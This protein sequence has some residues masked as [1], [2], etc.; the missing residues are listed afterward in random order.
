M[1]IYDFWKAVL[2]QNEIE[3]RKYF[4]NDAYINWHCTNEQFDVD[5]FIIANCEYPGDWE[6]NVER[7]ETLNDLIVTVV[8]VYPKG[9]NASF[10][11]TSFIKTKE[12]KIVSM[13][14]YW[15]DDGNAP[16][17][18]LDKHI[19]KTKKNNS[20]K[21]TIIQIPVYRTGAFG[22]TFR[23]RRLFYPA[24]WSIFSIKIP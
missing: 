6:G 18:R 3:I 7:V 17:W 21:G 12:D 13:D 23:E 16:Q 22:K 1:N 19:G 24:A 9:R 10:H 14:E 5:E 2:G 8:N 4:Q 15:A 11:V 20:Q